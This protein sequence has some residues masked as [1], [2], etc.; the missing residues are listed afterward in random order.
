MDASAACRELH[1][2]LRLVGCNTSKMQG[3]IIQKSIHKFSALNKFSD[4]CRPSQRIP[5]KPIMPKSF[6]ESVVKSA[7]DRTPKVH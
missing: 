4:L 6:N 3:I 2:A 5:V 1:V 7:K